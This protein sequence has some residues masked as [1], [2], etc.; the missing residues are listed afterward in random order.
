[1][2]GRDVQIF[3][4]TRR[5]H[6]E[7]R[8]CQVVDDRPEHEQAHHPPAE[9]PQLRQHVRILGFAT[10]IAGLPCALQQVDH[11]VERRLW[12]RCRSQSRGWFIRPRFSHESA[13]LRPQKVTRETRCDASR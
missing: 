11:R 7:R 12:L 6:R 10:E 4:D 9:S 5:G 1:M 13:S 2:L 8:S 3:E